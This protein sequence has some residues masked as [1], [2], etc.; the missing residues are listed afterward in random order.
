M[1]TVG[2]I[3]VDTFRFGMDRRRQRVAGVV[4]TVWD[5]ENGHLTRGGDIE[6]AKKF[7]P[8]YTLPEGTRSLSAVRG[9]LY[10][11][12]SDDIANEV[13]LGVQYQRLVAPG[14]P[15]M[16][17]VLDAKSFG[18]RNYV[19]A[20][21]GNGNIYHYYD[22]T[23]VTDWDAVVSATPEAIAESLADEI[24]ASEVAT[25]TAFGA[26]VTITA[27]TAGEAFSVSVLAV[28][29][30]SNNTEDI[31]VTQ[32]QANVEG[33][34]EETATA[35]ITITGGSSGATNKITSVTVNG[36]EILS[37]EV[38]WT[39]SNAATA[40]SLAGSITSL[41]ED[42]GYSAAVDGAVV[43]ISAGADT[44][45]TVNGHAIVVTTTGDVTVSADA[46]MTGGVTA[47]D[48][49]AQVERVTISGTTEI[50]D[51]FTVTL[52]GTDYKVT[53]L[54]SGMG[55]SVFVLQQ[56]V[57]STVGSLWRYSMLQQPTVWDPANVIADND[58]GALNISED[59]E[60]N[61]NLVGASQYQELGAVFSADRIALYS[62]DVDPDNFSFSQSLDNTGT[63]AGGSV[64]RYGNNDLFYLDYTGVRSVQAQQGTVAPY[65]VD[66]G[67]PIDSFLKDYLDTLTQQQVADA[68]AVIEP[69]DGRLWLAVGERIFVLS[70]FPN[71]NISGWSYYSPGFEVEAFARVGKKLYVRAG[72]TIYLYGGED[73]ATYPDAGETPIRVGLPFLHGDAVS[74]FKELTGFDL[75][76]TNDWEVDILYDPENED[77][78]FPV[79]TITKI[80]YNEMH[81]SAAGPGALFAPYLVCDAA[82]Q[83]T[84]TSLAIH[85]KVVKKV[86]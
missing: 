1:A 57:W 11:F 64:V 44:G 54:A 18:G 46:G 68:K 74:T 7:V 53:G 76:G 61:A 13:P 38:S 56:R 73:S 15:D 21:Y 22:A 23:R 50:E 70:R 45:D 83:A 51:T 84:L 40:I 75:A 10:V 60:G 77:R 48:S 41:A 72:D 65:V 9:Q 31:T 29:G 81:V 67:S 80:T 66:S 26:V 34:D 19:V 2:S 37:A 85:Y 71:A 24:N 82:G 86:A 43:T 14:S 63:V 4:G 47:V 33:V 39:G 20:K 30:G 6:R 3:V 35:D 79:G 12:G 58:A 42:T 78:S 32:L 17:K 27:R 5:L 28:D 69:S 62:V 16:T 36:V 8:V 52:D 49:V 25:A 55:T 59:S